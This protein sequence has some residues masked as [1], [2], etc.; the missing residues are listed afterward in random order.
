MADVHL[1]T[2]VEGS[3]VIDESNDF[4]NSIKIVEVHLSKADLESISDSVTYGKG[5][6][7]LRKRFIPGQWQLLITTRLW[8]QHRIEHGFLYQHGNLHENSASIDGYCNCGS[9]ISGTIAKYQGLEVIPLVCRITPRTTDNP[10]SKRPLRQPERARIGEQMCREREAGSV[11]RKRDADREMMFGEK[12]APHVYN[13]SVYKTSKCNF[14]QSQHIHEDAMTSIELLQLDDLVNVIRKTSKNPVMVQ[15]WTS[16]QIDMYVAYANSVDHPIM[17]V[18]ASGNLVQKV[19]RA[20]KRLSDPIFLYSGNS[21]CKTGQFSVVHMLSKSHSALTIAHWLEDWS[22]HIISRGVSL[23][24]EVVSDSAKALLIA[25]VKAFTH[26][27]TLNEYCNACY[28][29]KDIECFVRIDVAHFIKNYCDFFH[30]KTR[31]QKKFYMA[32]IGHLI[33]ATKFSDAEKIIGYLLTICQSETEGT[34]PDG[35][36]SYCLEAINALQQLL[37]KPSQEMTEIIDTS[38]N[39]TI[40]AGI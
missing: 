9:T 8:E 5:A 11:R 13:S 4:D 1:S 30:N 34:R 40:V 37:T 26:Y 39:E 29:G 33:L 36:D 14:K 25:S 18:D 2:S 3:S 7:R 17:V 28:I 23:P 38:L 22:Q 27:K 6:G 15:Y 24:K 32:A 12:V 35:T 31:V 20:D 16:S 21:H 10:C 19:F